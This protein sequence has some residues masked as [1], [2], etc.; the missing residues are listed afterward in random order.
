MEF[1]KRGVGK[2]RFHSLT[3]PTLLVQLTTPRKGTA[4]RNTGKG[5]KISHR[6]KH[7]Q[8]KKLF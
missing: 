3:L 2:V 4:A 7:R 6:E 8:G 5:K 1:L